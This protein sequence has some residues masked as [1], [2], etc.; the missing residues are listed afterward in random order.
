MCLAGRK[1]TYLGCPDSSEL[2]G[3]KAKSPCL[4]RLRPPFPLGAQDQG[5]QDSVPEPLVGVIGDGAG[6]PH[7]MRKDGSGLGLKTSSGHRLPQP[8]CWAVGQVLVLVSFV[9]L[10]LFVCFLF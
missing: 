10:F 8:V 1:P 6:K 4:Q 2:P 3:G 5:D 9:C 7:P